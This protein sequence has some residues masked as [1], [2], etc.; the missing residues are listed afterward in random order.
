MQQRRNDA[1]GTRRYARRPP[2]AHPAA[3]YC[4]DAQMFV[5]LRRLV[6]VAAA[7]RRVPLR[8]K[9]QRFPATYLFDLMDSCRFPKQG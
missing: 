2:H 9:L 5:C 1:G 3:S 7:A 8:P 4:R 6:L